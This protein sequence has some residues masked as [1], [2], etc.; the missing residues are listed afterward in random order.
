MILKPFLTLTVASSLTWLV[1]QAMMAPYEETGLNPY[2]I[3]EPCAVKPLCYDFSDV[4][5]FLNSATVKTALGVC[6]PP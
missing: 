2:D 4:T 5:D 6:N 1:Q 3:R